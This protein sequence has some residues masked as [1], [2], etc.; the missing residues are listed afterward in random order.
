MPKMPVKDVRLR[1]Y[2]TDQ[3]TLTVFKNFETLILRYKLFNMYNVYFL[4]T[5]LRIA[6]MKHTLS[7][8]YYAPKVFL[9]LISSLP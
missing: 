1:V 2:I 4:Y 9:I 3:N 7:G 8:Y 5:K 6:F